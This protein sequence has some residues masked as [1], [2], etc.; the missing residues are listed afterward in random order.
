MKKPD[1]KR[2][3]SFS[4]PFTKQKEYGFTLLEVLIAMSLLSIMVV[5][6]FSSLKVGA[7][8]WDKGESKIAEVN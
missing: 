2:S 6:L 4:G 1:T 7:E 8:S 5:L 3:R